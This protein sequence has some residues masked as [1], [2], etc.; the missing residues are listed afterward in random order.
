MGKRK[1][2][3]SKIPI[4]QAIDLYNQGKSFQSIADA[5]G[6]NYSYVRRTLMQNGITPR[7]A[8]T[9]AD[10]D[11]G[12][13]ISLYN[14]GRS[15]SKL[16]QDMGCSVNFLSKNLKTQ[17]IHVRNF[18]EQVS[19]DCSRGIEGHAI[20]NE[21]FFDDWSPEMA[22]VLGWIISD[23]NIPNTLKCFRICS[24]DIAHLRKIADLFS[25]GH[26][27]IIRKFPPSSNWRTAGDL[28]VGRRRMVKS[29]LR[30]GVT[31]QKSKTITMPEV[32]DVYFKHFLR[33]VF[34]GDGHVGVKLGK[35]KYPQIKVVIVSGSYNFLNEVGKKI[36]TIIGPRYK[37][38]YCDKA[39]TWHLSYYS[40]ADCFA[41]YKAMYAGVPSSMIL[42]R[43]FNVFANYFA[44]K[45]GGG[46]LGDSYQLPSG[47]QQKDRGLRPVKNL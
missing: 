5:F 21:Q 42:D 15:L 22:Y 10:I 8:I 3:C 13:V 1:R 12:K 33:G 32:P 11:W 6:V 30:L 7:K 43:K 27:I 34:E 4:Q 14:E 39:G 23:G 16:A 31:P 19:L 28:S 40:N 36:E 25:S 35:K 2:E 41:I 26:H 37:G 45:I 38:L 46:D 9:V 17:G 29:L 18:K 44:C 24:T 47:L 20:V